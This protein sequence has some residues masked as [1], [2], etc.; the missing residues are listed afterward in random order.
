MFHLFNKLEREKLLKPQGALLD[1][2]SGNGKMS[3]PFFNFGYQVTLVDKNKEILQKAEENFK[4]IKE[5]GFRILNSNVED[6][7][8]QERYDGIILSNVLPFQK[9]KESIETII[10]N[11]WDK[12]NEGGFLYLTLFGTKDQWAS[13]HADTMTFYEKEEAWNILKVSPYFSSESYGKGS[14]M[15]GDIKTWHIFDLLYIK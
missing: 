11:A 12:L 1:L 7:E 15:K 9:N 3:E 2:G 4:K 5:S 8:F 14:T 6:F 13:E 10:G